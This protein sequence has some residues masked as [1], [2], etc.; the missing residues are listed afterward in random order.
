M[1]AANLKSGGIVSVSATF[2]TGCSLKYFG[3]NLTPNGCSMS[4]SITEA[5][6]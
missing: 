6:Q 3:K 5:V 1:R 2:F 4:K